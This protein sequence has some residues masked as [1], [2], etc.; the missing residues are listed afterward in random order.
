MSANDTSK[1]LTA[2]PFAVLD[3]LRFYANGSHFSL[4]DKSSWDTVSGEPQNF[5]CDEAGTATVEDGSLAKAVLQGVPFADG[6]DAAPIVGEIYSTAPAAASD[7]VLLP[8][9]ETIDQDRHIVELR[10]EDEA[11]ADQFV[12]GLETP[13]PAG[14]AF[15]ANA[16]FAA[17]PAALTTCHAP[18]GSAA[19]Q[20]DVRESFEAAYV[21]NLNTQAIHRTLGMRD[22][23][24]AEIASLREGNRY[25]SDTLS[26]QY[27]GYLNGAWWGWTAA[28]AAQ[29]V[30]MDEREA[31]D[32]ENGNG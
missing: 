31:S 5:W 32:M 19:S 23:T 16:Q 3:A 9:P 30:C 4:A 26:Q 22:Y 13:A 15:P 8:M 10:F 17:V 12:A 28:C 29:G 25:K 6:D 27:I 7:K 21:Q 14:E 20:E 2:L 18:R 11:E 1:T 24:S